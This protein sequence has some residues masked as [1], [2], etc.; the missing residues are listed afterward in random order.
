M[1]GWSPKTL[2]A[3]VLISNRW[4]RVSCQSFDLLFISN[5]SVQNTCYQVC[6]CVCVCV[7]VRASHLLICSSFS[8]IIIIY[9]VVMMTLSHLAV[10]GIN[11]FPFRW[12]NFS[13]SCMWCWTL[14]HRLLACKANRSLIF[15]CVCGCASIG[16]SN[17][18][19]SNMFLSVYDAADSP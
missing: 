3:A 9:F 8:L 14:Y 6:V 10:M 4:L 2:W 12:N 19:S 1:V 7:C 5:W 17:I 16:R 15:L 13:L 11:F 18:I